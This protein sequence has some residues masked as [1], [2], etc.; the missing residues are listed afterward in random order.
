MSAR[1]SSG[2][3][4]S[5]RAV[6]PTVS[7]KSIVT[8][9]R[10][11]G[12]GLLQLTGNACQTP[13]VSRSGGHR[14]SRSGLLDGMILVLLLEAESPGYRLG[15]CL[16]VGWHPQEIHARTGGIHD[17]DIARDSLPLARQRNLVEDSARSTIDVFTVQLPDEAL[18][19]TLLNHAANFDVELVQEIF[20]CEFLG[21][22]K[23]DP[24]RHGHAMP[25]IDAPAI[26]ID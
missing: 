6:D 2:S 9:L 4:L 12:I 14:Q 20:P 7:A 16:N 13:T 24:L 23:D 10:C 25:G 21:G 5:P 17:I 18:P 11:S 22:G 19:H 8:S 15:R 1:R 26:G 3:R